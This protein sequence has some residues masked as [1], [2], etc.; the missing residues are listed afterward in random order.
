LGAV[1]ITYSDRVF[2][3]NYIGL[4]SAGMY[5]V[6]YQVGM[7]VYV[8]QNSFNQAW[9]PW[10]FE[11]LKND[12]K[13]EKIKIVRF[14]YLYFILILLFAL[15]IS[16]LAPFI[17]RIF[18]SNDYIKGIEIVIWITVGFA[19]NGMYKMVG[20]YIFFIKKTYIISIVTIFTAVINIGLNY[21]MV[22]TWGAVGVAQ[23]TAISFLLQFLLVWI[24]SA[25][26][27]KMPWRVSLW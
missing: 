5:S 10:F 16:Y 7:I 1:I 15:V 4:E 19:F 24:I 6:G 17:Y 21:Y 3:A 27:Y 23:A 12:D 8:I 25:K 2:I 11:R 20:N 9:V 22:N 26:M 13:T 14:T 18:I